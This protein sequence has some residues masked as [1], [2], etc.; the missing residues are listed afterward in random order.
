MIIYSLFT[1]T[2]ESECFRLVYLAHPAGR[3]GWWRRT[4]SAPRRCSS[5]GRMARRSPSPGSTA[6]VSA[7][8]R[9]ENREVR[10]E[11][12][13]T[14]PL[15]ITESGPVCV[16]VSGLSTSSCTEHFGSKTQHESSF[17]STNGRSVRSEPS[18]PGVRS[19]PSLPPLISSGT[20]HHR[21]SMQVGKQRC[22]VCAACLL[23]CKP[24][25]N[26]HFK[27]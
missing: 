2:R 14:F 15:V 13:V 22:A 5:P 24:P 27:C 10:R 18:S 6:G 26:R 4:C 20:K 23:R 11:L 19:L 16:D 7:E 25:L 21:A 3:C 1:Q 8:G 17:F 12:G 9:R